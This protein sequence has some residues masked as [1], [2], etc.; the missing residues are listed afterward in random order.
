VTWP[1]DGGQ[2]VHLTVA[3]AAH[4]T[5]AIS[6]N[7]YVARAS[8]STII[9][10]DHPV[11]ASRVMVFGSLGQGSTAAQGTTG[12]G[13][14]LYLAEG[15]TAN[16]F[17]EFLSLLNPRTTGSAHVTVTFY[18]G[19][20]TVIGTRTLTIGALRRGS[21]AVNSVTHASSV[22]AVIQSD[23]PLVVERMMYTGSPNGDTGGGTDV[24]AAAKPVAGWAFASGDTN[25]GH[26][27]FDV[28]FNPGNAATTVLATWYSAGGQLVQQRFSLPA[29]ARVTI[30]VVLAALALPAGS[31]GL[32]LQSVDGA[33]FVAE[34]AL[35]DSVL[36]QGGATL[37]T[38]IG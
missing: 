2:P 11:V 3:L 13:T 30:D 16:G 18:G 27:E 36:R 37:G 17:R 33:S 9:T 22:A 20:G 34:Q 28:L 6:V 25:S 5:R 8:H 29:H 38:P 12:A 14:T 1:R 26:K 24:L 10:S 15:S 4:A 21:L 31:H 7:Q 35:Y 32:V 23:V 19:A